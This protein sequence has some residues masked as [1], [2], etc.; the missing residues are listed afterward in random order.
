MVA[1]NQYNQDA[2]TEYTGTN[3]LGKT[4]H[5]EIVMKRVTFVINLCMFLVRSMS[6]HSKNAS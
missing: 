3:W 1:L 6:M 5:I 4:S 2:V